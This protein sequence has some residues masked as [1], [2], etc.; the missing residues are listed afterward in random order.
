MKKDSAVELA[1]IL[2]CLIVIGAHVR[3]NPWVEGA[4]DPS[5]AFLCCVVADG[6][7]V[8]WIIMGFFL[9][10]NSSY[11]KLWMKTTK[12]II[13]PLVMFSL[14]WLYFYGW[15]VEGKSLIESIAYQ[16]EEYWSM[17]K[18][19]LRW[20]NPIS[21]TSHLWYLYTYLM[22]ILIYPVLKAFVDYLDVDEIR[23]RCFL[24]ISFSFIILNDLSGNNM[25][26]FSHVSIN[27]LFPAAVEVIWGHI[28]Y[29]RREKFCKK[30][31]MFLS[32]GLFCFLN[33]IRWFIQKERYKLTPPNIEILYWFTSIGLLCAICIIVFSFS[34]LNCNKKVPIIN[35]II[36][37]LGSF[38]FSIYLI[39]PM[40]RDILQKYDIISKVKSVIWSQVS[41]FFGEVL[42]T[43][44]M[45]IIVFC[46][47]LM[48]VIAIRQMRILVSRVLREG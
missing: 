13:V 9:F 36:C 17:L 41:G 16:N 45:A 27:A 5:R 8:F 11:K 25:A 21:G 4:V 47:S 42:Y 37:Y 26:A 24:L 19:I 33:L 34:V 23:V 22:I 40:I 48:A 18:E 43:G 28:I 29:K 2:G 10:N 20:R 35:S 30:R 14:F 3:P 32:I 46:V 7:A 31:Y 12:N 38:T 15:I 6:V 1:R 39:H 44:C